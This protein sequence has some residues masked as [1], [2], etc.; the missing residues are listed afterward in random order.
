MSRAAQ[1]VGDGAR[2]VP[3]RVVTGDVVSDVLATMDK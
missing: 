3:I 2:A 1:A